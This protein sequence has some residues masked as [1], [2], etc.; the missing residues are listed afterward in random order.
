LIDNA[1]KYSKEKPQ[2]SVSTFNK[3]N[4][5]I[6]AIEDQGIGIPSAS[7]EKIFDKF[8]RVTSGNIHDVKGFGL[9]LYYVKQVIEGHDGKIKVKSELN[10][11]SR[12]EIWLGLK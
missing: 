12:F 3:D 9:G 11:G 4:F 10:K 5:L 2:V 8:Y 7:V 6:V 1:L